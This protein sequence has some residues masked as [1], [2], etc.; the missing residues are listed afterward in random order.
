VWCV[1]LP[2]CSITDST[3]A[4]HRLITSAATSDSSVVVECSSS[5][6][7]HVFDV[8][9]IESW[10]PVTM[11]RVIYPRSLFETITSTGGGSNISSSLV[12]H[13]GST[14]A[15]V[16]DSSPQV[17]AWLK[18]KRVWLGDTSRQSDISGVARRGAMILT[19]HWAVH[20]DTVPISLLHAA[21]SL[22]VRFYLCERD[23]TCATYTE[24]R[25]CCE[26]DDS[27]PYL[28]SLTTTCIVSVSNGM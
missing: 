8:I 7:V 3:Y 17:S 23:A 18:R 27:R 22:V 1:T 20:F 14:M 26:S 21:W 12:Q 2:Q 9:S 5:I 15:L 28:P 24:A 25:T 16:D 19:L 4:R 13:I 11:R 10:A 6:V